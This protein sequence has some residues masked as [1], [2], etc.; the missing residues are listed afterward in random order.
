[1]HTHRSITEPVLR[2]YLQKQVGDVG[3][4]TLLEQFLRRPDR[5][6]L[7]KSFLESVFAV[8]SLLFWADV[9]DFR[10]DF[11]SKTIDDAIALYRKY[12]APDAPLE[13]NLPSKD[14]RFFRDL[15]SA[16]HEE[17]LQK[18][19]NE[20]MF[21]NSAKQL[22]VLLEVNFVDLFRSGAGRTAWCQFQD[23]VNEQNIILNTN[24]SR[25][26]RVI[27][28]S[29]DQST[30]ASPSTVGGSARPVLLTSVEAR[31]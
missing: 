14:L 4:G 25:S 10:S 16:G 7:F 2:S 27:D 3:E 30:G 26:Q 31:T 13:V 23:E 20:T 28:R 18:H 15:F 8:E 12:L 1:M 6:L 29:S 17:E 5:L 9:N 11:K 24:G 21:D 22:I 19:F